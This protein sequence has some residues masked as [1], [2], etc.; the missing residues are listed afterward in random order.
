MT[1]DP[2]PDLPDFARTLAAL[3]RG[4]ACDRT[5][6]ADAAMTDAARLL[7]A[8]AEDFKRYAPRLCRNDCER[9]DHAAPAG[10][11]YVYEWPCTCGLDA[12]RQRWRLP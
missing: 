2:D 1:T 10:P 12:A 8:M 6:Y 5:A 4:A 9:W 7:R 11:A 3:D